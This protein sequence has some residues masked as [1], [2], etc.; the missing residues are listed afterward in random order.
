MNLTK[1]I[2]TSLFLA[3]L[4]GFAG[5]VT[6]SAQTP[7]GSSTSDDLQK[8]G[9]TISATAPATI[10][11][12]K[13]VLQINGFDFSLNDSRVSYNEATSRLEYTPIR[14]YSELDEV[15]VYVSAE[16]STGAKGE[17]TFSF[18]IHSLGP[19]P[20]Q[21]LSFDGSTLRWE[22]PFALGTLAKYKVYR[23]AGKFSDGG[24]AANFLA[25]TTDQ[26]YTDSTR[27]DG[28]KYFYAVTAV[29][30][31]GS[32]GKILFNVTT[33]GTVVPVGGPILPPTFPPGYGYGYPPIAPPVVPP[34]AQPFPQPGANFGGL[35]APMPSVPLSGRIDFVPKGAPLEVEKG[36]GTT[37][38]FSVTNGL[39]LDVSIR[40]EMSPASVGNG[41]VFLFPNQG[42]QLR[43]GRGAGFK[44]APGETTFVSLP[45]ATTENALP[46]LYSLGIDLVARDDEGNIVYTQTS[47]AQIA[48]YDHAPTAAPVPQFA[49]DTARATEDT[50]GIEARVLEAP[51]RTIRIAVEDAPGRKTMNQALAGRPAATANGNPVGF[52]SFAAFSGVTLFAGVLAIV[53]L[54]TY[55]LIR[56]SNDR[57]GSKRW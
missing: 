23:G 38:D 56:V 40:F 36:G 42:Q 27:A 50:A 32:E 11:K 16:D 49:E 3:C 21:A 25:E 22:K 57:T 24:K 14:P 5:A 19:A 10:M 28:A 45:L 35:S 1:I 12:D 52:F 6:F 9:V 13:I 39:P 41:S 37:A 31:A 43:Y 2:L 4:L 34:I 54:L 44:L 20:I 7:S 18:T 17:A 15:H 30:D 47:G 55:A 29:D 51:A 48:V 26:S 8:I 33:E 53:V 46:G